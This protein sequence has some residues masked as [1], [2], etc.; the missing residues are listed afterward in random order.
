MGYGTYVKADL[1]LSQV[2]K[3]DIPDKLQEIRE[4]ILTIRSRLLGL[5]T[6]TPRDIT[7]AGETD[8][9]WY[10]Y[11][12]WEDLMYELEVNLHMLWVLE[13]ANKQDAELD[14]DQP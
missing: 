1:Y 11:N 5:V 2:L 10:M 8:P 7:P 4:C 13:I 6:A 9:L 12:Q 14:E 3:K